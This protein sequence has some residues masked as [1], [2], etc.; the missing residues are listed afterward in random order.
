MVAAQ[1]GDKLSYQTLLRDCIP[2]IKQVARTQG[3][4][5]DAIDDVVQETLLTIHGARQTYDPSRSFVAWLRIIAQRRAIDGLRRSS[6]TIAREV[7]AP[8]AYENHPDGGTGPEA[9]V[10]DRD[11][12]ARLDA[13]IGA[14]PAAQR[15]AIEHFVFRG[16]S[17]APGVTVAARTNG[18]LRVSWHRAIKSLRAYIGEKD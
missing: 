2:F 1:E 17:V 9:A 13:A 7:H 4:H 11:R 6:R 10:F 12:S 14:L 16:H 15:N 3:V 8:L 5:P 18:S